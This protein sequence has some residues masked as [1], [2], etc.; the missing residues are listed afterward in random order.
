M[1]GTRNTHSNEVRALCEAPWFD[2]IEVFESSMT[3][4]RDWY[5]GL[6]PFVILSQRPNALPSL[7]HLILGDQIDPRTFGRLDA[8]DRIER[9]TYR[10]RRPVYFDA[11][12]EYLSRVDTR[13]LRVLDVSQVFEAPRLDPLEDWAEAMIRARPDVERMAS[14]GLE[15][16]ILGPHAPQRVWDAFPADLTGRAGAGL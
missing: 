5:G 3:E 6:S 2:Q 10:P 1:R 14:L 15:R 7:K 4:G 12:L 13:A 16:L 8:F 9:L 11:G